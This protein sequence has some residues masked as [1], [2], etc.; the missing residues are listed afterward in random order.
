MAD[1]VY[2][3]EK[4]KVTLQDVDNAPVAEGNPLYDVQQA[5]RAAEEDHH[6]AARQIGP[7]ALPYD[8]SRFQGEQPPMHVEGKV[9]QAFMEALKRQGQD[10]ARPQ[11]PPIAPES[12]QRQPRRERPVQTSQDGLQHNVLFQEIMNRLDGTTHHYDEVTLPSLGRFYDGS[13]GPVSGVVHVRQMTGEEE[14]ILAQPRY[15]KKG[16][17]IDMIFE[18]CVRE[19]IRAENLLGVDRTFLL[20]YLRGISYTPYYEVEIKCPECSNRFNTTIDL[21]I[22]DVE[23]CP[24]TFSSE[25]LSGL[26]PTSG[27]NFTYRLARG[28]DETQVQ[29]YREQMGKEFG[30]QRADDT[31][32]FRTSLLL[33]EIEGIRDKVQI[34]LIAKKLPIND[35]N[36]IRN[37]VNEPPFGVK[38]EIELSCAMCLAEFKIDL[39][40]ES[41]FFFPR[42][43]K[44]AQNT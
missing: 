17:A 37:L 25:K 38:T 43:K 19:P 22:L 24:D 28:T 18:K 20:I 16:K 26:L 30:D 14:E 32:A 41:N 6:A 35:L 34:K 42:R 12:R 44:S 36:Y 13:D 23:H 9:P 2:R 1:E 40:F 3:P 7:D 5:Q 39:P 10:Q 15:I 29:Q 31:M 4:R 27:L 21:N 33:E 11:P 8:Q